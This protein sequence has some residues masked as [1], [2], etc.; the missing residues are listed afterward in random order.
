MSGSNIFM[1]YANA[2][3]SNVTVS[4]RL[5]VG[6]VEPTTSGSTAQI[7]LLSGSGISNG[8][9]IANF[10]CKNICLPI[11]ENIPDTRQAV[12]AAAGQGAP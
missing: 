1:V 10:R 3:G 2:A 6:K 8:Q 11:D 5:G 7:T 9:M 4:P 12:T